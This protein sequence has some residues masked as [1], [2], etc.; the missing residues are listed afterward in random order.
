M[1]ARQVGGAGTPSYCSLFPLFS[2]PL[3]PC[4]CR[5]SQ[6]HSS[7]PCFRY[8]SLLS[9]SFQ[10][11]PCLFSPSCSFSSRCLSLYYSFYPLS[12]A[13]LSSLA[14]PRYSV[15]LRCVF[16]IRLCFRRRPNFF[17]V[18]SSHLVR[19]LLH[20]YRL[21]AQSSH[22]RL[23]LAFSRNH[24]LLGY[25]F[26]IRPCF[27][28][29][30]NLFPICSSHPLHFHLLDVYNCC[31]FLNNKQCL[32]YIFLYLIEVGITLVFIQVQSTC[33]VLLHSKFI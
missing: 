29:R 20:I 16:V 23:S 4:W 2:A 25:V 5:F 10:S 9:S 3:S 11:S 30:P 13:P 12:Y 14:S 21:I 19:F 32:K 24:I 28:H 8:P 33:I 7:F 1:A 22:C 17:R 27:R 18:Y 31:I 15:L 26:V 6:S